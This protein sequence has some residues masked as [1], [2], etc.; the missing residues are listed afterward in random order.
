[1][2]SSIQTKDKIIEAAIY[3]FNVKG[4]DGTS[5]REIAKKANVNIA[6]ISYYFNGKQGLLEHLVT[7][8]LEGYIAI[9]E[10]A[11]MKLE[12]ISPKECLIHMIRQLL[13]YQ[14]ENRRLARL[15][16]RE[17]TLDTVLIREVMTTY[18][19]KEKYYL[20]AILEKGM[21][22]KEFRKAPIPFIIMQL[23]SL[24]SMPFLQPIYMAEVL[25]VMP[26]ERYF[27]DQ[28]FKEIVNWVNKSLCNERSIQDQPL[29]AV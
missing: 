3:L 17:I 18:L 6:N 26:H 22:T 2:N 11:Y 5:V 10:S 12:Q 13:A 21:K 23:K 16:H 8:F 7:S 28:Y 15:V 24:V 29:A 4:Y 19:T 27:T 25:H 14:N 20:T 9:I 1:M